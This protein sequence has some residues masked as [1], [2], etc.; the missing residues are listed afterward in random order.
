MVR[1]VGRDHCGCVYVCVCVCVWIGLC[2]LVRVSVWVCIHGSVVVP[3]HTYHSH[4]HAIIVLYWLVARLKGCICV[5]TISLARTRKRSF[6]HVK[7]CIYLSSEFRCGRNLGLLRP[8]NPCN[9]LFTLRG[10][11][12][13]GHHWDP[14]PPPKPAPPARTTHKPA[15]E[16]VDE[17]VK[18]VGVEISTTK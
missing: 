4:A 18:V 1:Y 14:H 5:V 12:F 9:C 17:Y 3:H 7:G 11:F 16:V 10:F 6:K 13:M 15:K 2:A 8:Q